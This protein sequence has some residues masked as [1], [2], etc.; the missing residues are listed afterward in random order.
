MCVENAD[1]MR[2]FKEVEWNKSAKLFTL[3]NILNLFVY[4]NRVAQIITLNLTPYYIKLRQSLKILFSFYLLFFVSPF[5]L[6]GAISLC[7][8]MLLVFTFLNIMASAFHLEILKCNDW[9]LS[10][11]SFNS[12]VLFYIYRNEIS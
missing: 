9:C 1:R 6:E 2:G 10:L 5:K 4:L 11:S 7:F 12:W 8:F 3:S